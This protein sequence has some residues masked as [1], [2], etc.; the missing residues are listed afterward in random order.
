MS[1]RD[2]FKKS[3]ILAVVSTTII[4]FLAL[5]PIVNII[6]IPL[7]ENSTGIVSLASSKNTSPYTNYAKIFILL[8]IP[9]LVAIA[10]LNTHQ[11]LINSY[12]RVITRVAQ[13]VV[14][15]L[16]NTKIYAII[17]FT[18]VC[19]WSINKNYSAL[20]WTLTDTFHEGEYLGFLPNF[21]TFEKP[22]LKSF[23]V[24]GFGLDVL[25][26]LIANRFSDHSNTIALTRFLRMTQGLIGYLGCYWVIWE[27]VVSIKLSK[28]RQT[29]FL[30]LCL[31]FAIA[32][33][34]FFKFFTGTFAGRDTLFVLQLALVIRFFRITN[35]NLSKTEKPLLPVLIGISIP[36][37]FLYVYDRAAYFVLVYLFAC[38][39]SIY[40]EQ[41]L[42][43]S[44]VFR[45]AI[46]LAVSSVLLTAILGF[47]QIA[48]I[49]A[50]ILF[51]ARNGRYISFNVLPPLSIESF[52]LWVRLSSAI[53]T[54]VFTVL[55]LVLAYKKSFSLR[56]FLENNCLFIILLFAS[57]VYMRITL[58]KPSNVNYVGSSSLISMLLLL[59]LSLNSFKLCFADQISQLVSEPLI[60]R[61]AILLISLVILL[62]PVLNPFLSLTSLSGIYTTYR[63]P[64]TAI[65]TP[66]YLQ[67]YNT[68]KSEVSQNPCFFTLS[69]EGFWYY[70]F[71]KPSCSKFSIVYYARSTN[72]QETVVREVDATKPNIVLFGPTYRVN[73]FEGIPVGNAIPIIYRYFLSH[74]KPYILL[75]SQWFWKRTE[76]PLT[77]TRN[78]QSLDYGTIDTV[79][80]EKMF[81]GEIVLLGGAVIFSNQN[82]TADAVYIS[83]GEDNQ[84]IEVAKVDH[85]LK[86]SV[87]IPT[88]SLPAGRSVL[89]VWSYNDKSDQLR[90][91]GEDIKINLI[92]QHN[93]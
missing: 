61:S 90:Q 77:F 5:I 25:T 14:N 57:L 9:S 70:L 13:K 1:N 46:G 71:N 39:L 45:S 48:E 43:S 50:Q 84:L 34:I 7:E 68:L 40:F 8:L 91:I 35:N 29:I 16:S 11:N 44:F 76:K 65:A 92:A 38:G 52:L 56:N 15:F 89:R 75:E 33:G 49:S 32:D 81:K 73:A 80:G 12:W 54:Q 41:K 74:Y 23:M 22:F 85:N 83:Y 3:N 66:N 4:S 21:L 18:L 30:L 88:M 37:S 19:L 63:T 72:A 6:H 82:N 42:F 2:N 10:T 78:N 79:L 20:N 53:L 27:L 55:Y 67:V 60:R 24:H 87:P 26:S 69:Q 51:W 47:D 62:H 93:F 17:V 28:Q 59:Y 36:V 64:D 58:D 86:W 31:I